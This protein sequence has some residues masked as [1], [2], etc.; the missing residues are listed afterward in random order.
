MPGEEP[1]RRP[2]S[3]VCP[4]IETDMDAP[5]VTGLNIASADQS[6]LLWGPPG[7]GKTTETGFRTSI[8]AVNGDLRPSE[9]TVV[10]YRTALSD[11]LRRKLVSWGV[12]PEMTLSPTSE[13]NP[14]RYWGTAHAVACRATDFLEQFDDG[15]KWTSEHEGIVD[16]SVK[17]AWCDE[18]NIRF[19]ALKPWHDTPASTFFDL[20]TYAK[21]NL[22][23]VGTYDL[24]D[25]Y[26][27]G[28]IAEDPRAW[29]LLNA[30][31]QQWGGGIDLFHK[32]VDLWESFKSRHNCA[33]YWEQ[34]EAGILGPLPPLKHIVIDELHDAYPLMAVYFDRLVEHADTVIIAGDPDQVCNAFAGA[35]RAIFKQLPERVDR[36]IPTVILPESYRCPDEHFAAA[37]RVLRDAH[38]PPE[39]ATAGPGSMYRDKPDTK[40]RYGRGWQL[41]PAGEQSSPYQLWQEFGPGMLILARTGFFLD[42]IGAHLDREGVVYE[43]QTG[44]AGNWTARLT[45]LRCLNLCEGYRP[46]RQTSILNAE[47]EGSDTRNVETAT[48]TKLTYDDARRFIRHIDTRTLQGDRDDVRDTLAKYQKSDI[49]LTLANF[50]SD[51]VTDEFW[52]VYGNGQNSIN[53]LVR[54]NA[55]Q[56]FCGNRTRDVVAMKRAWDRYGGIAAADTVRSL[57]NGT[58]LLTIHAA[59]GSQAPTTVLYDGLTR[60]IEKDVR[61]HKAAARNEARTW[62]VGLTRASDTLYVVR[63]AFTHIW[64][65]YLPPDLEP[66]AAAKAAKN[67]SVATDGGTNNR[68]GLK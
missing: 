18:M 17:Y 62:Y 52:S 21:Q 11:S 27:R 7:G 54:L 13:D 25:E 66:V 46:P 60:R 51:I 55:R 3:D 26:L 32:I 6:V 36:D 22:L 49:T 59:K 5:H 39:L 9:C 57:A 65:S 19:H 42:G 61:N 58:R 41:P 24:P 14:Y 35:D 4:A 67:R 68:G 44:N 40:M 37:A 1:E 50:Y 33:D 16:A 23:D 31:T 8:R 29:R 53:N 30:F 20:Y 43:S 38:E 45:V 2:L 15:G 12:F 64:D 28:P 63:D 56:S 10:T 47:Y 34:L 48:R